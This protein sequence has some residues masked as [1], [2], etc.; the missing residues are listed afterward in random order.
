MSTNRLLF[1]RSR[2]LEGLDGAASHTPPEVFG[3][4][5]SRRP[6]SLAMILVRKHQARACQRSHNTCGA[7]TPITL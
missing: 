4:T 5:P 6:E 2:W 3:P 7:E 1:G